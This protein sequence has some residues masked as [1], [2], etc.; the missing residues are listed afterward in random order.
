MIDRHHGWNTSLKPLFIGVTL[1]LILTL[2]AYRIIAYKHLSAMIIDEILLGLCFTQAIL[3]AIFFL[4]VGLE[5]KPRWNTITFL[6]TILI[7]IVIVGGSLWIMHNL[8]YN[9]MP[10]K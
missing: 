10:K 5:S 1:S 8:N 4:Q 2:G 9:V 7:L 3:Q 6:F